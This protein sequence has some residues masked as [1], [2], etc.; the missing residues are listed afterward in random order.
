[1]VPPRKEILTM[2]EPSDET[3]HTAPSAPLMLLG[4]TL[5]MVRFYSRLPIPSIGS[6]DDPADPPPF[7]RACRMLPL[8]S[9]LIAL[10]M[11]MIAGL[12]SFT[13]VPPIVSAAIALAVA[14]LSTGA[15]HE[16]GLADVADGFGGGWTKERKLE[17]MKDSR[18]GSY[19]VAALALGLIA[20]AG[21]IAALIGTGVLALGGALLAAAIVSRTASLA[22]FAILPPARPSGVASAVGQPTSRSVGIAVALGLVL[23]FACLASS[24]T[25]TAIITAL[26]VV[27]IVI[28]AFG[29]LASAQ[30]GGQTGDVVGAAQVLA[31]IAFLAGLVAL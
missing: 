27:A 29:R 12:L 10:P 7:G 3:A 15:L 24:F 30:I 4:D 21:L 17:I 28:S 20:R 18:V 25:T 13:H 1:M 8:A 16:D 6:F 11:T 14:L 2:I 5:A 22:L 9:L 31:E 19:G 26:I 23:T